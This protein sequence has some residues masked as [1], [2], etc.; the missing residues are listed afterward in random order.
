[1]VA[2]QPG[3]AWS[4]VE[5]GAAYAHLERPGDAV[6]YLEPPLTAGYPDPKGELHAQLA[7]ALGRLGRR[8]EAQRASA[9]ASRLAN[10]FLSERAERTDDH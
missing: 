2:L 10:A 5:L 6:H 4:K 8:Q 3:N 9:E 1:M 7:V